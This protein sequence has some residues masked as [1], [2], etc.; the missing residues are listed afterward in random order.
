MRFAPRSMLWIATTM[1]CL[2]G[3]PA[4]DPCALSD[5]ASF[6]L[7]VGEREFAP[8]AE[9]DVLPQTFGPQGGTHISFA[10]Q[11]H[12][13]DLGKRGAFGWSDGPEVYLLLTHDEHMLGEFEYAP[14]FRGDTEAGEALDVQLRPYTWEL[15]EVEDPPWDVSLTVALKDACGTELEQVGTYVLEF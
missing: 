9:G 11:T 8:L 2:A 3:C 1:S 14:R 10:L 6:E 15:E 4:E 13:Y 7:G 5:E 12:G